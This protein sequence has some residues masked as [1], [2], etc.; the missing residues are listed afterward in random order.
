MQ[1]NILP[2]LKKKKWANGENRYQTDIL[3]RSWQ[4]SHE[5]KQQDE[6]LFDQSGWSVLRNKVPNTPPDKNSHSES[7]SYYYN[8][9]VK[10]SNMPES[11][12]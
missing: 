3:K 12:R 2:K 4:F 9:I 10:N 5:E 7:G 11:D 6:L 1:K 8:V